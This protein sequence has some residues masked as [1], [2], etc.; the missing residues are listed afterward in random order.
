MDITV[1]LDTEMSL[2][3]QAFAIVVG[4]EG[5]LSIDPND[6]GNYRDG[7][8]VGTKYGI[9]AASHPG[10]DI[11]NLTIDQAKAIHLAQYWTPAGCSFLLPRG[12]VC[13]YDCAIN[14]GLS[15]ATRLM[16]RAVGVP[17]D[18]IIGIETQA[19][20]G[21]ATSVHIARF[22]GLRA[23]RYANTLN[24]SADGEGWMRRMFTVVLAP[25]Q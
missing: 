20:F 4:A 12:A 19:A 24:F 8:L 3:D 21:K 10:V 16:Q 2:F 15:T 23:V 18:G 6:P 22:M 5:K 7:M 1:E 25:L 9:D 13:L 11:I 14:Q 17:P